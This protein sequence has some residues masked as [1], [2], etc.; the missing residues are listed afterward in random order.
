M[1][2]QDRT[3][4]RADEARPTA[5]EQHVTPRDDAGADVGGGEPEPVKIIYDSPVEASEAVESAEQAGVPAE[6]I[7]TFDPRRHMDE[8]ERRAADSRAV[9]PVVKRALVGIVLGAIAGTALGTLALAAFAPDLIGDGTWPYHVLGGALFFAPLAAAWGGFFAA[10]TR[11]A[12]ADEARDVLAPGAD[13]I[14]E[15]EIDPED[16]EEARAARHAVL[17]EDAPGRDAIIDEDP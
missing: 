16:P 6:H 8:E 11:V 1:A 7:R 14:A 9:R 4:Q 17:D 12:Q 15:V 3:D 2:H 13:D 5:E 10:G